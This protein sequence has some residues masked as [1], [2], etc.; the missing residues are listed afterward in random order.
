MCAFPSAWSAPAG[1]RSRAGAH[2]CAR[3]RT[4][5]ARAVRL[6][7]VF[8]GLDYNYSC[9][10]DEAQTPH[11]PPEDIPAEIRAAGI[12]QRLGILAYVVTHY[13]TAAYI[14]GKQRIVGDDVLSQSVGFGVGEYAVGIVCQ[15]CVDHLLGDHFIARNRAIN[16]HGTADEDTLENQKYAKHGTNDIR[17]RGKGGILIPPLDQE[18]EQSQTGQPE[19]NAKKHAAGGIS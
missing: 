3:G 19:Q 4:C 6:L 17:H 13:L 18:E 15:I 14:V 12:S 7:R 10:N 2:P 16:R 8:H 11:Y 5:A 9:D 1:A